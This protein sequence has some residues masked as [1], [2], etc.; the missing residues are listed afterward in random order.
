MSYSK[1]F[2]VIIVNDDLSKA[3]KET[4]NIVSSFLTN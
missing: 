1:W 2:D 4:L 3:Q